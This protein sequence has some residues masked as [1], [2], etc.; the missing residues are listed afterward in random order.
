MKT[1]K[2][3][4]LG[5]VEDNLKKGDKMVKEYDSAMNELKYIHKK[6]IDFSPNKYSM[7][8]NIYTHFEPLL[9]VHQ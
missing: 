5:N 7:R 4:L 6:L 9:D 2:E 8:Y 3:S 1:L